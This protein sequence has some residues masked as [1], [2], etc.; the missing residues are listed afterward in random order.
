MANRLVTI[1]VFVPLAIVLIALSVANRHDVTV[2]LDPFNPGN[3]ALSYSAPLFV[4][5][6]GVLIAGL[7]FGGMVTWFTQGKYRKLAR[8]R[9]AE[10]DR[11]RYS[12][13]QS[14]GGKTGEPGSQTQLPALR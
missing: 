12:A 10:A 6:F 5:L 8:A 11:L 4:W 2:T 3:P 9:K 1:I 7:V 13:E 14:E